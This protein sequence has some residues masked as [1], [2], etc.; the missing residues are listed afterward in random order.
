MPLA[1]L[2]SASLAE[3]NWI[4]PGYVAPGSI[5]LL[6]GRPK[7]GKST[8][9]FALMAAID[10]GAL[11]C[12]RRPRR[13]AIV[14][15]SEE[16]GTT[17]AEKARTRSWS[18]AVSILLHH[19][20]Y[21]IGWPEIVRHAAAHVGPGGLVIVD[22]LADFAGLAA[23]AENN[24]GAIQSAM[25]PLQEIA[26]AG[27]AV[28]VVSHQRKAAGEH[29][30]AVRGSNAL[31]A[32]VDV[33][34]E[35]ERAPGSIGDHGRVLKAVSRFG[36]TPTDLVVRRTDDGYE[37]IGELASATAASE[38]ERAAMR[39]AELGEVTAEELAGDI[40]LSKGT[41]QRR[42]DALLSAGR[43]V[44]SGS[45]KRGDAYRWR[46]G[47]DAATGIPYGRIESTAGSGRDRPTGPVLESTHTAREAR[48]ESNRD[49]DAFD[50]ANESHPD[51]PM[52]AALT[53]LG[54]G[55][56][57]WLPGAGA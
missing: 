33:V 6:A 34:V 54:A 3:P 4:W 53:D 1:Q 15:L 55:E 36:A 49:P 42:L 45:G 52:R 2:A 12:G 24:A 25:R 31:T 56:P 30:E 14:V 51:D 43:V 38:L 9:L 8:L 23:D 35:F 39:V 26:G 7:V 57:R 11:F 18:A 21:S 44:R 16:R 17:I 10:G 27:L 40:G 22:T 13:V 5:T 29:G 20:A 28:L 19:T 32:A 41:V 46:T 48:V 47:S 37:A 50:R